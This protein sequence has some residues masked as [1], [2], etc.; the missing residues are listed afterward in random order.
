MF[1]PQIPILLGADT[2]NPYNLPNIAARYDLSDL[3]SLVYDGSNRLTLA[4]DLSGNSAVNG[5]VMNGTAGNRASLVTGTNLTTSA[6]TLAIKFV[7][8]PSISV[9]AY[10]AGL[11]SSLTTLETGRVF[12]VDIDSG[13]GGSIR[14]RINGATAGDFNYADFYNLI[15]NFS[16]QVVTVTIVR[17]ISGTVVVYFNAAAQSVGGS[18]SAGTPPTWQGSVTSTNLLMGVDDSTNFGF[19]STLYAVRLYSVALN[20]TGVLAD[21]NGTVQANCLVNCDYSL[22]TK[23]SSSFACVTGQTVTIVTSGDTGARICGARDAY[24]ATTGKKPIL[25]ISGTGNYATYDEV[26]D[27]NKS[28]PYSANQ[29]LTRITVFSAAAWGSGE[30]LWDGN[31]AGSAKFYQNTGTPRLTINAGSDGPTLTTFTLGS[32]AIGVE[33]IN[34]ASSTLQRNRDAAVTGTAGAGNPGG[35]TL[36]SGGGGANASSLVFR[37]RIEFSVALDSATI[38]RCVK[39]LARKWGT[40]V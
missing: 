3:S 23:L 16:N 38:D 29:P 25:T 6:F 24:Q 26:N 9:A 10:L 37:E 32:I 14:V 2:F 36:G 40:P 21:Y 7:V 31:S 5:L 15:T 11:S 28:A 13:N 4:S 1:G 17:D 19:N 18:G 20:A 39:Y 33:V 12:S 34:N 35:T 27:F 30:V 22:A 8:P